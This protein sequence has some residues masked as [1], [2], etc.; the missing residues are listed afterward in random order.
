MLRLTYCSRPAVLP[1]E[2][3]K[4]IR[5]INNNKVPGSDDLN[6]ELTKAINDDSKMMARLT[7]LC[8]QI[9]SEGK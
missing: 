2:V 8:N 5:H 3:T 6:I 1:A 7:H 4:Y 9:I